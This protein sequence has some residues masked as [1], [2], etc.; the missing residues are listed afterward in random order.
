MPAKAKHKTI[1][2]LPLTKE[3]DLDL[4]QQNGIA[5]RKAGKVLRSYHHLKRHIN[6][7]HIV[8]GIKP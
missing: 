4:S 2:P 5:E 6:N 8:D 7:I 3:V 1:P